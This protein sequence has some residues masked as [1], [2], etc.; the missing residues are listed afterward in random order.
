VFLDEIANSRE[1]RGRQAPS[2]GYAHSGYR[3]LIN[4]P[5]SFVL[6]ETALVGGGYPLLHFPQKP[7]IV[8]HQ[9]FDRILHKRLRV[10]ALFGSEA[11][12]LGLQVGGE[13]DFHSLT[14]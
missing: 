6:D 5:M 4:V 1:A 3:L 8:I 14:W 11:S 9:A 13:V 12:Q 10:A 7:V 2:S